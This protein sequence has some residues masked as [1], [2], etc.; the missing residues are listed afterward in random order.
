[1]RTF[2]LGIFPPDHGGNHT[3]TPK[4]IPRIDTFMKTKILSL[5]LLTSLLC[6]PAFCGEIHDAAKSGDLEKVMA[7]LKDNPN[8]VSSKDDNGWTPLHRAAALGHKDAVA[9]LLASKAETN[10]RD[11]DGETLLHFAAELGHADVVELLLANKAEVNAKN[12]NGNT[13]LHA[14]VVE[15]HKDVAEALRQHRGHE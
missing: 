10:A 4:K 2:L 11:N 9:L 7:L 3:P 6:R 14:A 15:G 12:K 13:P 5:L 1:M 8:L